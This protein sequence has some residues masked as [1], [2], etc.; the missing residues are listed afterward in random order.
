MSYCVTAWYVDKLSVSA[1]TVNASGSYVEGQTA[2]LVCQSSSHGD[3]QLAWMKDG[4]QLG[5]DGDG[6]GSST[7]TLSELTSRDSGQYVCVATRHHESITSTP[8]SI[9]VT[10]HTRTFFVLRTMFRA[11]SR[12][13]PL[14]KSETSRHRYAGMLVVFFLIFCHFPWSVTFVHCAQTAEDIQANSF[15]YDSPMFL[16]DRVRIWLTSVDPLLPNFA[17]IHPLIWASETFD[18]KL[19]P[20]C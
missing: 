18:G 17:L 19:R 1:W 8:I 20:N 14:S 11:V 13:S 16:P 7:L 9:S 10:E 6:E 15:A 4:R 5:H 12:S 3:V 2:V